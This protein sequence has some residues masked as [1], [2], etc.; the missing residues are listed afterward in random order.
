MRHFL[1]NNLLRHQ[2]GFTLLEFL[3]VI[4]I[5]AIASSFVYPQIGKWK[6]KRNIEQDFNAIVSTISYLKTKTRA[7]NGTSILFC[8]K[9]YGTDSP[10]LKYEISRYRNAGDSLLVLSP[11]YTDNKIETGPADL[12]GTGKF[13]NLLTGKVNVECTADK[14]IFN[15][16]GN[17]GNLGSGDAVEFIIN[18]KVSGVADYVN[19][20]AY[21][22]KVNTSTAYVQKYKWNIVTGTWR[23]LN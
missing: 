22:V 8:S 7:I 20:N 1:K 16:G 3:V 12:D 17:A 10:A 9:V 15:A 18:Y 5:I 11:G 23:E 2:S 13:S 4:G 19:F 14:T 6:I 21:K